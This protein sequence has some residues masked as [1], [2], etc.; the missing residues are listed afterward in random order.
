MQHNRS[1]RRLWDVD[2]TAV[3]DEVT[4]VAAPDF[5]EWVAARGPWAL[6]PGWSGGVDGSV[7]LPTSSA[8]TD[9]G[10]TACASL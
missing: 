2:A 3:R 5:D 4:P 8:S 10:R 7:P 1:E 9:R 6:S